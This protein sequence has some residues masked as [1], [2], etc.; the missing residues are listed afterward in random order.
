MNLSLRSGICCPL[1]LALWVL[2]PAGA[3]AGWIPAFSP[4]GSLTVWKY[5]RGC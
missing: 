3:R 5:S 2:T 1:V 4:E